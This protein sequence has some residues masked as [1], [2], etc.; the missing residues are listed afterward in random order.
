MATIT[1]PE[2]VL[3]RQ[4]Q[5]PEIAESSPSDSAADDWARLRDV[6]LTKP[7]LHFPTN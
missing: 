4:P 2:A 5:T 1:A 6:I 3:V 7:V